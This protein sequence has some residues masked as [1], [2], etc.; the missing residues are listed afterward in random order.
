MPS[1]S[2]ARPLL[3]LIALAVLP[4]AAQ[5]KPAAG[6]AVDF[7]RD[8]LPIFQR[9]CFDCHQEPKEVNG[10]LKKPKAGLRMDA[11]RALVKGGDSGATIV[12]GSTS[13]S[14]LFEVIRLPSGDPDAM[15]PK[16]KGEPLSAAEIDTVGR[17]IQQGAKFGTW[18]GNE[19][20]LPPAPAV[21]A[22]TVFDPWNTGSKETASLAASGVVMSTLDEAKGLLRVEF[23][24]ESRKIKDDHL[25]GLQENV[26]KITDLD[27]SRTSVT[28]AGLEI[29][30][31]MP[32]LKR[33][34]LRGTS[35]T[36]AALAHV[37]GLTNLQHLNLV[38]TKVTDAGLP[39]LKGLKNLKTAYFTDSLV[40]NAGLEPLRKALPNAKLILGGW[41][42][43]EPEKPKK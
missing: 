35:V 13:E 26:A 41:D 6:A 12:P 5:Q 3:C 8:V 17:W 31:K 29:L 28:D 4:A 30:R 42:G 36:D 22:G 11:A 14:H 9:S 21:P 27:L 37:Q 25:A 15:P 16:N 39:A 33:L 43:F 38:G 10:Q 32:Q 1:F 34:N 24:T 7:A 40:T 18:K 19:R 2:A 23:A 20:G